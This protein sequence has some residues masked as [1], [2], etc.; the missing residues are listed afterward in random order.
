MGILVWGFVL[1]WQG[2]RQDV[3]AAS[4]PMV[5]LSVDVPK[6]TEQSPKAMENFFASL[7]GA[8]SSLTW[9][10]TWVLGKYQP[11]FTFEIVSVDGYIQYYF[12]CEK[13]YRDVLEAGIYAQYPDAQIAEAEDW[14]SLMPTDYPDQEWDMWGSELTLD[15]A[16]Y[17]PIR[18]WL[19]FEHSLSQELKDPLA[20]ILEQLGR[21]KP[22]EIFV[23]QL[24]TQVIKQNWQ[25]EG[26]KY[27]RKMYGL[28]EETKKGIAESAVG[29]ALALPSGVLEQT[30]G[31]NLLNMFGMGAEPDKPEDIWKAFKITLEEKGM[32]EGVNDKCTKVGLQIKLRLCY[33]GRKEVYDKRARTAMVKGMMNQFAYLNKFG[34]YGPQTPKDDYFW[35]M[36]TYAKRQTRLTSA[37]KKRSFSIGAPRRILNAEELATIWHFP[38]IT[39]KAPL[40]K[41]TESRRAEPPVGLPVAIEDTHPSRP[42]RES[43]VPRPTSLLPASGAPATAV[44]AAPSARVE[45]Q[46]PKTD[47]APRVSSSSR[48][49]PPPAAVP[50]APQ[51][52]VQPPVAAPSVPSVRASQPHIPDAMRVLLEPGVEL[53]DVQLPPSEETPEDK[54]DDAPENLPM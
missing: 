48:K 23:V 34:L 12:R 21:M 42:A 44:G 40:V 41:K 5:L 54:T 45:I 10:E 24:V 2:Y 46:L 29:A 6:M 37:L 14:T 36:W 22:G 51:V 8:H 25:K 7:Q 1:I 53:E 28:K 13:R 50:L 35:Q 15:K 47:V 33:F 31:V 39:I 26:S 11:R 38:T 52:T 18:T 32:V 9:K 19:Q 3:Y 49:A 30:V 17:F 27:I 43:F 20:V 16:D 4:L